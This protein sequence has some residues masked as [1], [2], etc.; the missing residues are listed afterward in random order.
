QGPFTQGPFMQGPFTQ[1]PFTQG[2]FTQGPFTQE[3]FT[4]GP[5][6][7]GPFTEGPS[8]ALEV[9]RPGFQ[10]ACVT[11]RAKCSHHSNRGSQD[12]DIKPSQHQQLAA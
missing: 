5:F 1:G 6:T 8:R 10:E 4:Q 2:P 3:P 11:C 9:Q 7:Q 12:H